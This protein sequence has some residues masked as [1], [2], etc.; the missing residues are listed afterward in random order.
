MQITS[1]NIMEWFDGK[2]TIIGAILMVTITFLQ[3]KGYIDDMTAVYL[4]SLST[5][6]LGVGIGHKI[7][8]SKTK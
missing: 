1:K 8:K 6:I 2:K 5:I 3:Q 4:G 7:L